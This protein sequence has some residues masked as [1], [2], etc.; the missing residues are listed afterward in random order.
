MAL[1]TQ[2]SDAAANAAANAVC[3]LANGGALKIYSTPQPANANTSVTSQNLLATLALSATAFGNAAAGVAT[4]NSITSAAAVYTAA[5]VWFR[6]LKSDG[7]TVVFDGTIG[8][9]SGFNLI[10]NSTAIQSG[11]TVAVSSLAYSIVEAGS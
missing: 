3:A 4:S 5:A 8:T 10:M 9:G 7:S 2:L 1:N 6:I 11:S